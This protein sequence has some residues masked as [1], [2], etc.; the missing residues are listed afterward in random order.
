M[1]ILPPPNRAN[2][3]VEKKKSGKMGNLKEAKYY[4]LKI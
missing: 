2:P 1:I 3:S 4:F